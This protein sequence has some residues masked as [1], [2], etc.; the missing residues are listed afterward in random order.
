MTTVRVHCFGLVTSYA[1]DVYSQETALYINQALKYNTINVY[2]E[3]QM[4][5]R[6]TKQNIIG[7][8]VYTNNSLRIAKKQTKSDK[9]KKSN[10]LKKKDDS[11]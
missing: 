7:I 9:S 4:A 10:L 8:E 2:T 5:Q 11:H 6:L 3:K 1:K